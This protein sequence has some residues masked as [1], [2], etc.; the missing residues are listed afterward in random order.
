M[1]RLK[2]YTRSL[3]SGYVQLGANSLYTLLSIPLALH[4]LPDKAEFG[5]WA[6]TSQI[7]GY[8]AFVDLGLSASAA[9]VL[10]DYKDHQSRKEYGCTVLTAQCVAL[11][12]ALLVFL[13][14]IAMA[15]TLGPLLNIQAD[16]GAKFFWLV[17]G[18]SAVTAL[19]F[20]TRIFGHI[21]AAHQR[22]DVANYGSA[23]GMGVNALTMWLTFA[24]GAG[25]FSL[26]WGQT[27]G[28]IAAATVDL[29]GCAKLHFL[30]GRG[31]WGRPSW[32]RFRELFSYSFDFF[33]LLMGD[34]FVNA[35]Q[36][37]ILTRIIGLEAAAIWTVCTRTYVVL[38]QIVGRIWDYSTSAMAEMMVRGE[39]EI[40]LRR[41]REI[42][43]LTAN[44]SVAAGIMYAI[45]NSS[46]VTFWT[47]G[48]ISWPSVNNVLVGLWLI[49]GTCT[50]VHAGLVAQTKRFG[51]QRFIYFVE[52]AAFIALTLSLHRFGGITMML[53]AS[54][55]CS[56][57][58]S[59]PYGLHRTRLFFGLT[60]RELAGWYRDTLALALAIIP[61]AAAVW[62]FTRHLPPIE[63]F[64]ANAVI[65]GAWAATAFLRYGLVPSLRESAA[66]RAPE[67]IKPLFRH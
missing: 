16:L 22:F 23:L 41:F 43:I 53:C 56:L 50:R 46:F 11:T 7:A 35:S 17:A 13:V 15:A 18:Q 63:Q 59:L 21:L 29:L 3:V 33:L 52:G 37:L 6:L 12:Q 47:S 62:W 25:V 1:S 20:V 31:N 55:A 58:F 40:L 61:V 65:V 34:K 27:A 9:R 26:L 42:V 45:C 32:H 49:I 24:H 64:L 10:V 5:L 51:F 54:I 8:I 66:R 2:R 4:Y 48:R 57:C 44:L 38:T 28:V 14:G 19:M 39:R 67:W 36:T 60:H 30:P